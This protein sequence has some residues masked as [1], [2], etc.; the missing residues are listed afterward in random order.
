ML[1]APAPPEAK[2]A[3]RTDRPGVAVG[4]CWTAAG[5][6]VLVVEASRMLGSGGLAL[7]GRL[8]EAMQESAH[9][10]LSWLRAHAER[11]GIDP[12]S[13]RT[14]T[15]IC[16]CRARRRRT[17]PPPASR[18]RPRWSPRAPGAPSAPAWP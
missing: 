10:A 3:G 7:T 14:P 15:S 13:P 2:L 12:A 8:G 1:G 18:W 11:Y 5:G 16:T 17:A 6:D 9:V 4:L